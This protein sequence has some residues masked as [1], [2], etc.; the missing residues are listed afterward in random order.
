MY[1][2]GVLFKD[3]ATEINFYE[4]KKKERQVFA[5]FEMYLGVMVFVPFSFY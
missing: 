5:V 2:I 1:N 3:G 4:K